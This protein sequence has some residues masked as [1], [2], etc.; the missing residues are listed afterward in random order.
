M[1][2]GRKGESELHNVINLQKGRV[3][4]FTL[5]NFHLQVQGFWDVINLIPAAS[6]SIKIPLR[7]QDGGNKK[8]NAEPKTTSIH[9]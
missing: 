4:I 6:T 9:S 1:S 2:H 5:Y 8:E 7:G 3:S